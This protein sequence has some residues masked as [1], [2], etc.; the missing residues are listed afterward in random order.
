MD[1]IIL[2]RID[3]IYTIYIYMYIQYVRIYVHTRYEYIH[4]VLIMM[5]MY[6]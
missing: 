3:T 5:H 4:Y 2:M 6:L 1:V